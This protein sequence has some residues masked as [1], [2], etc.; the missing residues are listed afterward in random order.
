MYKK[1]VITA[2]M[3][4]SIN[5]NAGLITQDVS[6]GTQ[7]SVTDTPLGNLNESLSV[8]RFDSS[9]GTLD[10]VTLRLFAQ[11]DS[12]GTSQNVS[13]A[14]GRANVGIFLF[15]DWEVNNSEIG[16]N[17]VFQN[18]STTTPLLSAES[19]A[20][21]IF[22]LIPDSAEDTFSY[23]LSSGLFEVTMSNFDT[24]MFTN[25][26]GSDPLDFIFSTFANTNINNDVE[27]GTGRFLNSF[28]SGTFGRVA[29]DYAYTEAQEPPGG[30]T[31]V[32]E[33]ASLA[34]FG[35]GLAGLAL[36]RKQKS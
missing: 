20:E 30:T 27:S 29:L 34:I 31:S 15:T 13:E 8:D 22:T 21:N 26:N 12:M 35:L 17:H 2:L 14:N 11:I 28:N 33:P 10:S 1:L 4:A 16:F 25:A 5:A 24:N 32:P 18:G 3:A 7:G 36:R 23:S 19:S 6:F 9:L